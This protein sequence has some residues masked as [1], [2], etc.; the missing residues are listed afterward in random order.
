MLF[1]SHIGFI[2]PATSYSLSSFLTGL[3]E[4]TLIANSRF[5]GEGETQPNLALTMGLGVVFSAKSILL[6]ISGKS[7]APV[8]KKLF[9]GTL[10]SDIPASFL[11]LHPDVT[12]ILDRDAAD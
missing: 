7:K 11:L 10:H 5:F 3:T 12:V 2:E 4:S 8:A 9:E 6:L 1:R